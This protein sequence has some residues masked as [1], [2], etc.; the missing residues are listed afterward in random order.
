MS[1]SYRDKIMHNILTATGPDISTRPSID[2][3]PDVAHAINLLIKTIAY[4]EP[5][6]LSEARV[7]ASPEIR[8]MSWPEWLI[9]CSPKGNE[10]R[11]AY[12][13]IDVLIEEP[14]RRG[15]ASH[16]SPIRRSKDQSRRSR[17]HVD[18]S[19]PERQRGRPFADSNSDQLF[20]SSTD[21]ILSLRCRLESLQIGPACYLPAVQGSCRP[22]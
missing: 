3:F 6:P 5:R 22:Q 13:A 16:W 20:P 10:V 2:G 1:D 8:H 12:S 11:K 17:R 21:S 4:E 14:T 7:I 15:G 18:P 19:N 9:E